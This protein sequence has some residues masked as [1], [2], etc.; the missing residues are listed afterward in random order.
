MK[1]IACVAFAA[2]VLMLRAAPASACDPDWDWCGRSWDDIWYEPD[3]YEPA[4]YEPV[5]EPVYEPSWYW[6]EPAPVYDPPVFEPEPLPLYAPAYEPVDTYTPFLPEVAADSA[7][8]WTEVVEWSNP[9]SEAPDADERRA[10]LGLHWVTDVYV[11]DTVTSQGLTTT[12]ATTTASI[13]AGT[14]ARLVTTVATG[15]RSSF[16]ALLFNPRMTLSDGRPVSGSVYENYV[17]NGNDW[18]VDKYVFFQ[19]D[20]ET[21]S[22]PLVALRP[23]STTPS[24]AFPGG[25]LDTDSST[26]YIA[27]LTSDL[28]PSPVGGPDRSADAPGPARSREVRVGIALAPQA[29]PL[30]RVEVLRGRRVALWIRATV[31]GSPARVT[32]WT[33]LP[34]ELTALGP[35][36]GTGDEP[37][38]ATW[39]S[40]SGAPYTVRATATVDVPGEASRQI[41]ATIDVIV[42]S[43]ALV[44]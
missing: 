30:G 26:A 15:E 24:G 7:P 43:P 20:S 2:A 13:D 44:E 11:A 36:S 10:E 39:R 1:F 4:P 32:G 33:L 21:G 18:V 25:G 34:G 8:T 41:E 37:L 17:W 12:Y 23:P 5:Y 27:P 6:W 14:S 31:D 9:R 38:L 42:R 16:D 29:D 19:D 35:L 40:L 3:R 28:E 22:V